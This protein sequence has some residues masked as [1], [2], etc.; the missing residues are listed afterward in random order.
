VQF[1]F[2]WNLIDQ[3]DE[4]CDFTVG[5]DKVIVVK[6]EKVGVRSE[7]NGILL[8][9]TILQ[10]PVNSSSDIIQIELYKAEVTRTILQVFRDV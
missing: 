9:D 6:G 2:V 4:D 5:P 7:Y 10:T 3:T 1:C 8:L